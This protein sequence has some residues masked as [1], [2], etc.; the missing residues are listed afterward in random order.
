LP[1]ENPVGISAHH[2]D[3]N[4]P[5][6]D[7]AE[8]GHG[9]SHAHPHEHEHSPGHHHGHDHEH[10]HVHPHTHEHTAQGSDHD[11][12][13]PQAPSGGQRTLDL[14]RAILDKNDR[15][16]ER[17]RGFFR[18]RGVLVLDVLS[19]PGSG[20]TTF[21]RETIRALKKRL[22]TGVIVGDLAT[23]NDAQRLRE[24][25]SPV[26]QITTGTVCH[27]EAEM[28]ARAVK[29]LDL[30]G[31]ELLIIENVG[32][33]VCPAAYDL[34]EDLRIVLF[35]VTEGED[36]PLKYPPIFQSADVVVISK[37]DL[38]TA[39]EFARDA[40]LRNLQRAAPKARVFEVS[41][42]TGQGMEAWLDFLV[43]QQQVRKASDPLSV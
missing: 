31:L 27:L 23:D 28:V 3:H 43:Q 17:N 37:S 11:H 42:K 32:N 36:K 12:D 4:H 24:A 15:L 30:D 25:G 5:H 21:L 16:A 41:A 2:H 35:S 14:H 13:H 38:A 26:V 8:Q 39:C 6:D 1:G 7:Q 9:H 10:L 19:S 33:L 20:K 18:A 22:K 34:G 29:Q 40:A